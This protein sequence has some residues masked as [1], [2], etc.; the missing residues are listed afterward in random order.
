MT[1]HTPGPLGLPEHWHRAERGIGD[2][3]CGGW[4]VRNKKNNPVCLVFDTHRSTNAVVTDEINAKLVAAAP[5]HALLLR[6]LI[7]EK[8]CI[9]YAPGNEMYLRIDGDAWRIRLDEF[10]CPLLS[11]GARKQLRDMMGE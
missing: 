10:G 4:V 3:F 1:K 7:A 9:G 2:D 5:D 8:C 11:D 6:A